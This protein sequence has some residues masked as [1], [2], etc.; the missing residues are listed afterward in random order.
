M[1]APATRRTAITALGAGMAGLALLSLS[2]PNAAFAAISSA[3]G[4]V[5]GG[6]L[7]G[8]NGPIQFSALGT[9]MQLDDAPDLVFQGT[10]AWY[11]PAGMDGAPL[12]IALVAIESYGPRDGDIETARVMTGTASV[13]GEGAH[14]FGL[15]V[16]DAGEIGASVDLVRLVVGSATAEVTGTPVPTGAE[17][18]FDYDI[19]GELTTGNIQVV[20]FA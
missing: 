14:P 12:T 3:A 7:D 5:A 10:L 17:T 15:R 8:P 20:T 18:G 16:V 4:M 13:N 19:E 2:T 9:R 1:D 6:S 11:D